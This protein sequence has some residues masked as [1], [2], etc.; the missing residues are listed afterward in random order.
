[1][2]NVFET[3]TT[4]EL[5]S[6]INQLSPSSPALWGKMNV[7]QMLA[8]CCVS[9]EMVYDNIHKAPNFF[10]KLMLRLFAK[11]VVLGDQPYKRSIP[12]APAFI[13]TDSKDFEKEKARLI[14]Y[15]EK[16][17]ELGETYFDNRE[18]LSFGKLSIA[19]WNTLF[20][21][22]LDHHLTQFGV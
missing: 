13:I 8:H 14:A 19:Q 1:M 15:I 12:T 6:R 4:N 2:K 21:K 9:Y 17:R 11:G 5:I 18:S 3:N 16:T 22:H 7:A 20:Y 10:M